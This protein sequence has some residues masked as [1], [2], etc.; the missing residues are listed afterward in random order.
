MYIKHYLKEKLISFLKGLLIIIVIA[1]ILLAVIYVVSVLIYFTTPYP[2]P[3][4]ELLRKAAFNRACEAWNT[5]YKCNNNTFAKPIL[6]Y[7]DVD[8]E[9]EKVYSVSE[10]CQ[11][12]KLNDKT[13]YERCGCKYS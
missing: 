13:C 5:T 10:L 6:H 11:L 1:A 8:D 9:K 4:P 3:P 12:L 2:A 7:Q